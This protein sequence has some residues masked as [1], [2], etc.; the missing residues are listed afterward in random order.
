MTKYSGLYET[1]VGYITHS[2]IYINGALH[3]AP[4]ILNI[5]DLMS[6]TDELKDKDLSL[7]LEN[8][9]SYP[10]F[11]ANLNYNADVGLFHRSYEFYYNSEIST[12]AYVESGTATTE[13]HIQKYNVSDSWLVFGSEHDGDRKI[14]LT[15]IAFEPDKMNAY[16]DPNKGVAPAH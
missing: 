7:I 3:E 5:Q 10:T 9:G 12:Y 8:G 1:S 4:R 16:I 13:I 6:H 2:Y 15:V 14:T 11:L